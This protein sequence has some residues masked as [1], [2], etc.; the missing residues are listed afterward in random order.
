MS[1]ANERR[2]PLVRVARALCL[3]ALLGAHRGAPARAEEPADAAAAPAPNPSPKWAPPELQRRIDAAIDRGVAYLSARQGETGKWLRPLTETGMAWDVGHNALCGLALRHGGVPAS[4][5]RVRS[6]RDAVATSLRSRWSRHRNQPAVDVYAAG[7]AVQFLLDAGARSDDELVVGTVAM[8]DDAYCSDGSWDY[9]PIW[10]APPRSRQGVA[11][12][13]RGATGNCSTTLYALFGLRA[14]HAR[15]IPV[16]DTAALRLRATVMQAQCP[17][18][19]FYYKIFEPSIVGGRPT[20]DP[21][22]FGA[23]VSWL[24]SYL[25]AGEISGA[26]T[27]PEEAAKDPLQVKA[28]AWLSEHMDQAGWRI[29]GRDAHISCATYNLYA[30]ERVGMLLDSTKVG[31]TSWYEDGARELLAHQQSNGSWQVSVNPGAYPPWLRTAFAVLFLARATEPIGRATTPRDRFAV[32]GS[33][34]DGFDLTGAWRL[35]RLEWYDLYHAAVERM[36]TLSGA[37]R[38]EFAARFSGFG[39]RIVRVLVGDLDSDDPSRRAAANDVLRALT[40]EELDYDPE[41]TPSSRRSAT[42]F[43]TRWLGAFEARLR[44]VDGKLVI[45]PAEGE[46]ER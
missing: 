39:P 22:Y 10:A 46:D 11:S 35:R 8:L 45:G 27:S 7:L 32:T 26:C 44:L 31:S 40:G 24:A 37:R 14:A 33:T 4:D 42:E 29:S 3:V 30:L 12:S 17:D 38:A 6:A 25:M 43:W 19:G 5:P 23:T 13:A 2:R 21:E 15:G 28:A 18:G 41:G 36:S 9:L 20:G 1:A 34:T 16:S